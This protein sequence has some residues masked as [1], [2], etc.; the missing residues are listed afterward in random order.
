MAN[1]YDKYSN[2]DFSMFE[3]GLSS[4]EK[5]AAR[6]IV[7]LPPLPNNK[8]QADMKLV[9]KKKKTVFE[10]KAEMRAAA[11]RSFKALAV[12]VFL[13]SMFAALLFSK[14]KVDELDRKINRTQTQLTAAQAENVKLNMKLDSMI[15]LEKVEDYAQNTLGMVKVENYQIEYIDLS[16]EDRVNIS[17]GKQTSKSDSN[18]SEK[19]IFTKLLEYIG[20]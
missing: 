15:S 2:Y 5:N 10:A 12:A 19:T 1:N 4:Y 9:K 14:L 16:G 13:L 6:K 7:E 8:K 17:G 20:A 11:L 3:P 18:Q